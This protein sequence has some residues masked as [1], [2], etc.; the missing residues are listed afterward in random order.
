MIHFNSLFYSFVIVQIIAMLRVIFTIF[1]I[2]IYFSTLTHACCIPNP[3][4]GPWLYHPNTFEEE[5]LW[6]EKLWTTQLLKRWALSSVTRVL[7]RCGRT[8]F[9]P[10]PCATWDWFCSQCI[11]PLKFVGSFC[12]SKANRCKASHASSSRESFF[13]TSLNMHILAEGTMTINIAHYTCL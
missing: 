13:C 8:C 3:S 6:M 4:C 1:L 7:Y 10:L 2:C 9:S 11:H 5:K 12:V